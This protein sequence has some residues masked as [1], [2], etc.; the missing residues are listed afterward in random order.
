MRCSTPPTG[1]RRC[2]L[3]ARVGVVR[4]LPVVQLVEHPR[5]DGRQLLHGQVDVVEAPLQAM[6]EQPGHPG[7]DGRG[8]VGAGQLAQLQPLAP[9]ALLRAEVDVVAE[10]AEAA[11]DVHVGHAEGARVVVL[12]PDAEQGPELG[13]D[14]RLLEDFPHGRDACWDMDGVSGDAKNSRNV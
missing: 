4:E 6:Q 14:P 5:V 12:L 10:R 8:V 3:P 7:R 1:R 2:R 13:A 9:Q 11:D